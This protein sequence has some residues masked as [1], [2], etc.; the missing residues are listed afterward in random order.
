MNADTK[1]S[2]AKSVDNNEVNKKT[3]NKAKSAAEQNIAPPKTVSKAIL[4]R[5]SRAS[6]HFSGIKRMIE[7][8]RDYNEILIQLSAVRA[9]I[10]GLGKAILSERIDGCVDALKSEGN[11]QTVNDLKAVIKK[12]L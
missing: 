11:E 6:G 10:D 12:L 4:N 2:N 1:K 7:S 5:I 8:G 9:E 3:Q